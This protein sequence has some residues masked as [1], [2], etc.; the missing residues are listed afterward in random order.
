MNDIDDKK[1][2]IGEIEAFLREHE[3]AASTFGRLCLN[4]PSFF[5]RLQ[6]PEF[7]PLTRTVKR[8]RQ[9]MANRRKN[10]AKSASLDDL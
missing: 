8:V 10:A 6:E 5:D 3:M 4:N 1:T 2:L 9:W 7:S